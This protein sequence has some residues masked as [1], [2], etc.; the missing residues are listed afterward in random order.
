FQGASLLDREGARSL[1]KRLRGARGPAG[2]AVREAALSLG[3]QPA[4]VEDLGERE[5]TRQSDLGRIVAI[6]AQLEDGAELALQLE[7]RF[8]ASVATGIH[9]LTL[10]RSKGL[11]WDAVFLPRL[12]DGELP[13][14]RGDVDEERRL[15][16]VGVTRARRHLHVSWSGK[17]S[18]FLA[19]L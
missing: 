14:R 1:L 3:W 13:I 10:H 8:G 6:A 18:R 9:L 15:L 17:P 2:E 4:P 16:Y 19:E 12:E 5:Q 11:E 7:R